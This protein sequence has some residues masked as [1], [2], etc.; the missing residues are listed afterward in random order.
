MEKPGTYPQKKGEEKISAGMSVEKEDL[1]GKNR[2][3]PYLLVM[4][5]VTSRTVSASLGSEARLSSILRME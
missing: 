5:A 2:S 4:F 3:F 1:C